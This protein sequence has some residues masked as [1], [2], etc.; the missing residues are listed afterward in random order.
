VESLEQLNAHSDS[1]YIVIFCKHISDIPTV[2][3]FWMSC[4]Y[5]FPSCIRPAQAGNLP[6]HFHFQSHSQWQRLFQAYCKEFP[7]RHLCYPIWLGPF[8]AFCPNWVI[9]EESNQLIGKI[10]ERLI[11]Q[12][13]FDVSCLYALP[14]LITE[15]RGNFAYNLTQA[16]SSYSIFVFH[17][18]TFSI[19]IWR[20]LPHSIFKRKNQ[21]N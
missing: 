7:S 16:F 15:N 14:R 1:D 6:F 11:R 9:R 5:T 8:G 17:S 21:I 20:I 12:F 13:P 19:S 4:L 10:K 18:K 3:K 2:V